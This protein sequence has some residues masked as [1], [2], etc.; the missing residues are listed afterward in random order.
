MRPFLPH[1]LPRLLIAFPF[2]APLHTCHQNN[3]YVQQNTT[4]RCKYTHER[5]FLCLFIHETYSKHNNVRYCIE[6]FLTERSTFQS[7]SPEGDTVL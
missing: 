7:Y 4:K 3:K 6:E 5:R 1:P 2:L